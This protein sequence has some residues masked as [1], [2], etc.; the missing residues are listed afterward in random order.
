MGINALPEDEQDGK[1]RISIILWGLTSL[2]IEESSSPSMLADANEGKGKGKGKG[3]QMGICRNFQSGYCAYGDRCIF[4]HKD[5]D[6][7]DDGICRNFQRTG[8]C[9]FGDRCK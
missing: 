5:G 6:T 3:K 2:A 4:A 7:R 8:S 9:S 1:G